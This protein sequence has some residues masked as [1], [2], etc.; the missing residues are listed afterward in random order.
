MTED[1]RALLPKILNAGAVFLGQNTPE[2][3][4]DYMAGP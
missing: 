4:G 3:L 2:P 1:P